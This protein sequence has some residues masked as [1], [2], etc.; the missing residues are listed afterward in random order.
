M[1]FTFGHDV[2][3]DRPAFI[4]PTARLFGHVRAGEGCSFW[5]YAVVR[6]EGPE[7]RLGAFCNVQD[8][9]MLHIGGG[10]P[11][12]IGD[13]CTI[14][15]RA[16]VHGATIGDDCLIGIGATVMDGARVGRRSVIAGHCIVTA[17]RDSPEGSVVAGVPAKIVAQRDNYAQTRRNALIYYRNALHY[18]QGRH[19]AWH[20]EEFQASRTEITRRLAAGEDVRP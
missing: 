12:I 14:S 20:G 17:G 13:F 7:V 1:S 8:H 2:Q 6:A 9:A 19:D 5:T 4:D 3:L 15:H 11:T 18:A 16:I 10:K